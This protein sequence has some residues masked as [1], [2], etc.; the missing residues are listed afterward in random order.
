VEGPQRRDAHTVMF[1]YRAEKSKIFGVI[2]RP[3]AKVY[4]KTERRRAKY[5]PEPSSWV[6]KILSVGAKLGGHVLVMQ[7]A[8]R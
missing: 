7:C 5:S 4:L 2:R 1:K 8:G 6:R 3:V